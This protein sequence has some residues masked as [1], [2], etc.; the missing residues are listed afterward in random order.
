[1]HRYGNRS[2]RAI[3]PTP[4]EVGAGR[5]KRRGKTYRKR[6]KRPVSAAGASGQSLFFAGFWVPRPEFRRTH[7]EPHSHFVVLKRESERFSNLGYLYKNSNLSGPRLLINDLKS[8]IFDTRKVPHSSPA[9]RNRKKQQP[10]GT[11][12]DRSRPAQWVQKKRERHFFHYFLFF[13][14]RINFNFV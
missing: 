4:G 10:Q 6:S 9:G 7:R 13:K 14:C 12:I 2:G 1:M 3:R 8:F 5:P 11:I